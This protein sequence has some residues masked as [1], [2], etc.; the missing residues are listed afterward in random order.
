MRAL[1]LFL[2]AALAGAESRAETG[3]VRAEPYSRVHVAVG[4]VHTVFHD[5]SGDFYDP[6]AG[7]AV[8]A[9]TPF[10]VGVLEAAVEELL[11]RLDD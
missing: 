5:L 8:S 6:G 10:P 3:E 7:L 4:G 9:T 11:G 2:C 1:I